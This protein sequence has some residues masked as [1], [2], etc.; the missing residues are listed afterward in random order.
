MTKKHEPTAESRAQVEALASFGTPHD[1]IA[2]FIGVSAPTLRKA[3]RDELDFSAIKAN[4]QV[5][6]YLYSLAS[7]RAVLDGAKHADC[8]TAAIF[9]MK[10][11]AGW[12]ETSDVNLSVNGGGA[13]KLE[14][15]DPQEAAEAYQKMVDGG[16][17]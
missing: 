14:T 6:K 11:R 1:D 5:G 9:W 13:L 2:M 12:R 17:K 4:A 16:V 15:T 7:G 10:T 3:Y 8:R